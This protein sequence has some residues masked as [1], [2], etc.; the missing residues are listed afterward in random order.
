MDS[1][2]EKIVQNVLEE[3]QTSNPDQTSLIIAHRLSTIRSCDL[4]GV[5]DKGYLIEC[6]T[7]NELMRR[8]AAYYRMVSRDSEAL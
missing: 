6:D 8:R 4:I 7:H 5:L 1:H 2:N 3:I